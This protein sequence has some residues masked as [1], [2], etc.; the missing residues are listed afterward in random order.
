M[1]LQLVQKLDGINPV[2]SL[3]IKD[4]GDKTIDDLITEKNK[5]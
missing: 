3:T 4:T 5:S 1:L 2:I